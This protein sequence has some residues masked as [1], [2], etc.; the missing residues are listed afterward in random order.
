[1]F[2]LWLHHVQI[3]K[4]QELIVNIPN[5]HATCLLIDLV[6]LIIVRIYL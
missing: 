3:D 2:Q 6:R 5:V 4:L 1:M